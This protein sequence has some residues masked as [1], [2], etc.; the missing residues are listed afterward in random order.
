MGETPLSFLRIWRF[1]WTR[2]RKELLLAQL[3]ALLATLAAIPIP[4]L[5]PLL[6]DELILGQQGY[7][8]QWLGL[9]GIHGAGAIILATLVAVLGLRGSYTALQILQAKLFQTISKGVAAWIRE[10]LLDHLQRASLKE[11]ELL[12]T[13]A[14]ASRF[15]SDVESLDTF[16]SGSVSKLLISI[17]MLLGV[18]SVLVA[19]HWQLALFILLL[20][21]IVILFSTKLAQKVAKLK[22]E[23]NRAIEMFQEALVETLDLL[24]QIRGANKEPLFFGRLKERVEELRERSIAFGYRSEAGIRLSFLLFVSGFELFRAAGI[25]AVLYSDLSVGLMM[26]IFAY[27]WF[28]MTPI[29]DL[30]N[31]QY[32]YKSAAVALERINALF[33]L[34][35]EP[36]YPHRFNPFQERR[37]VGITVQSLSF[38]Y[39]EDLPILHDLSLQIDP[40]SRTAIVG[41]SGS[42]KSTLCKLLVGFYPIEKGEIRYNQIPIHQIGLDLVRAHVAY[43]PQFPRLFNATIRFNLTLADP[44][45]P[46]R[47]W[48]ALEMVHLAQWVRQLPAGLDT[49]VGRGGVRLSGGQRQRIAL[50]RMILRS[51]KVV[52]LDEATSG[53]DVEME[54]QIFKA[55]EP[56]LKERTT[57]LV[58]HRAST[59][60][61]ADVIYVLKEGRIGERIDFHRY[62]AEFG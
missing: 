3:T 37:P 60:Q 40:G 21:P 13:G 58:A 16:L 44:I 42:G 2:Y 59:I 30:I 57:I 41:A 22:R 31:I 49:P 48:E 11:Y 32:A 6:V 10:R 12:G 19:I 4:L 20:N 1:I 51:P 45:D 9:L 62:K 52:I 18:A 47:I 33:A 43:V 29:Q 7:W 55:M 27:L 23:Q 17:L 15:I 50:A 53:I 8:S 54:R 5:M 36:H 38:A 24:D 56:F 35:Q 34:R 25:A 61:Q 26:A 28:M 39:D 46:Q 14:I